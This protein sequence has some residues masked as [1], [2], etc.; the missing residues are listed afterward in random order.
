MSKFK[1]KKLNLLGKLKYVYELIYYYKNW[2]TILINRLFKLA[3]ER[4]HLRN[5]IT[6]LGGS[7]SLILDLSDEIFLRNV[8][9]PSKMKINPGDIVM[10]VGANIGLFSLFAAT[11][12]AKKLYSIEPLS[13]NIEIINKNFD[14][15]GFIRPIVINC[16][17]SDKNK[18][19]RLYIGEI[20]SHGSLFSYLGA[21]KSNSFKL[22][23]IMTLDRIIKIYNIKHV[24]FLKIDCEGSE[25]AIIKS[26]DKRIWGMIDKISIEYH[27]NVSS[28][29][30]VKIAKK[31]STFGYNIES[32]STS[33][34]YGYIYAW[35]S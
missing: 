7:N 19:G 10:D 25:G 5:N 23:K 22:I 14:I 21:N 35:K 8:Y 6:L 30:H 29:N 1:K 16:A 24:D 11:C 33:N 4:I 34:T 15:N 28:L 3:T 31:L 9:N 32:I 2:L 12:G 27:D 17:V 13:S 26:T 20:D 18:F